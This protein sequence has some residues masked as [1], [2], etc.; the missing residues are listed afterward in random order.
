MR[1]PV[2]GR[3]WMFVEASLAG[4]VNAAAEVND[5]GDFDHVRGTGVE[6]QDGRWSCARGLVRVERNGLANGCPNKLVRR[7]SGG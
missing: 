7:A 2:H 4:E 5:G 6:R 1:Q 3:R